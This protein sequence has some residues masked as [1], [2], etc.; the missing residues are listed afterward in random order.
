MMM[1]FLFQSVWKE[2]RRC[3]KIE[4]IGDNK[5][6]FSADVYDSMELVPWIRT[7]ICRIEYISFSNKKIEK[8][9][10]EDIEKMYQMYEIE[11]K[12]DF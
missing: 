5:L 8:Q 2:K 4:E 12:N 9:F 6:K 1:N 11:V 3:G 10:K 7:F